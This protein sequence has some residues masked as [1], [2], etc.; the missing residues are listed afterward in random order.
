[1][2]TNENISSHLRW[3]RYFMMPAKLNFWDQ[4]NYIFTTRLYSFS[5]RAHPL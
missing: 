5:I 2:A 4:H 1:M 3:S